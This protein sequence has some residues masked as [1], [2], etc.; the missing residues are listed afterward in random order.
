M[1]DIAFLSDFLTSSGVMS[2]EVFDESAD[3]FGIASAGAPIACF[4]LE[5]DASSVSLKK[6]SIGLS[7]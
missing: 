4:I 6:S 5:G 3:M 7:S 1:L 2:N